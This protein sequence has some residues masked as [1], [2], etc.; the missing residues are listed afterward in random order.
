MAAGVPRRSSSSTA[1]IIVSPVPITSTVSPRLTWSKLDV[2]R[3][4][5][6]CWA[7]IEPE[8]AEPW[9]P[10]ASTTLAHIRAVWSFKVSTAT[11]LPGLV[12]MSVTARW[13]T[14]RFLQLFSASARQCL[15]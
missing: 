12:W 5:S 7:Q 13:S 8:K 4:G 2:L 10:V 11:L 15:M 1:S 14:L 3:A 6:V 9:F